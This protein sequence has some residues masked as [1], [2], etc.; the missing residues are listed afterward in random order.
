MK[1]DSGFTKYKVIGGYVLTAILITLSLSLIYQQLNSLAFHRSQSN[2]DNE[3]VFLISNTVTALYE[4]E[5][6]GNAFI[7]SGW[8]Q[9]LDEYLATVDSVKYNLDR[10]KIVAHNE[11]QRVRIDSIFLLIDRK[12]TNLRNIALAKNSFEPDLFYSKTIQSIRMNKDSVRI[13]RNIRSKQVTKQDSVLVKNEKRKKRFRLFAAAE[14]DS[15]LQIVISNHTETDTV[16]TVQPLHTSDTLIHILEDNRQQLQDEQQKVNRLI[17][18]REQIL[19]R[20]S[21]TITRHIR[22]LLNEYERLELQ[23]VYEKTMHRETVLRRTTRIIASIGVVSIFIILFLCFYIL[24]DLSRSHRY[25]VELEKANLYADQL[26]I[27]R[28]RLLLTVTHDIKSPLHSIKGYIDLLKERTTERESYNFLLTMENSAQHILKLITNMLDFSRLE[29]KQIRLEESNFIPANL[30]NEIA[31]GFVPMA[32]RKG[33]EFNVESDPS[34]RKTVKGDALRIRQV[35]ENLLS[36]AIK[37]TEQGSIRFAARLLSSTSDGNRY[38]LIVNLSDTGCGMTETEQQE[39][40]GEFT[41][42]KDHAAIEGTGLGLN[43]TRKILDLL[44]GEIILRSKKGEGSQFTLTI[45]LIAASNEAK[46]KEV[47]SNEAEGKEAESNEG[48]GKE[49]GSNEAFASS[50]RVLILDDDKTLSSLIS[51]QLERVGIACDVLNEPEKLESQLQKQHHHLLLTDIQMPGRNGFEVIEALRSSSCTHLATFPVI[52]MSGSTEWN[53]DDY[54]RMGFSGFLPKP[55]AVTDFLTLAAPFF[56]PML[57][58]DLTPIRSFTDND[59]E[60]LHQILR[61]FIENTS[62]QVRL[63]KEADEAG[64]SVGIKQLAHKMLPMFRQLAVENIVPILVKIEETDLE[65]DASEEVHVA[66]AHLISLIPPLL[67][68]LEKEISHYNSMP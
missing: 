9:H 58:Y 37:Y 49:V 5:V 24:R 31:L 56:P 55:F 60:V 42:L 53:S 7:Q 34:L 63:L 20:Q 21:A 36:N 45:P 64:N 19:I 16:H 18:R 57:G 23:A 51:H 26:L 61:S 32:A 13:V 22:R 52:A 11:E 29:K 35:L 65:K 48:E 3:Q 44:N 12:I 39:V 62:E 14:P 68:A 47:G 4:A 40:F 17:S 25:R 8:A 54:A 15:I 46:G 67:E 38:E 27:A 10:M 59:P 50:P 2:P 41:R 1:K 43:I 30:I 6:L 66:V 33:L 28:E